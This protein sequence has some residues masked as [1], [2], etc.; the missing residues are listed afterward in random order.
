[1]DYLIGGRYEIQFILSLSS[2]QSAAFIETYCIHSTNLSFK[3][4]IQ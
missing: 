1:M 4:K 2:D 3:I